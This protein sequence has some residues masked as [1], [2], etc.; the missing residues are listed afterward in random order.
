MA[1]VLPTVVCIRQQQG[2]R[3]LDLGDDGGSVQAPDQTSGVGGL[4]DRL[5]APARC[6]LTIRMIGVS[7]RASSVQRS[8]SRSNI[9][10]PNPVD[11]N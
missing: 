11:Q 5:I 4:A 10:T 1:E 6:G 9:Q 7:E 2:R 8:T 3:T